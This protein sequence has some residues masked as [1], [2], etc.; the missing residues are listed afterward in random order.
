MADTR[1]AAGW[2]RGPPAKS[3]CVCAAAKR[4]STAMQALVLPALLAQ[5]RQGECSSR[6]QASRPQVTSQGR[7][8]GVRLGP[9]AAAAVPAASRSFR[10]HAQ[11][12]KGPAR[13]VTADVEDNNGPQWEVIQLREDE[14][15]RDA[16]GE[17][18]K[19]SMPAEMRCFD[20]A[21][22]YIKAGDGGNGATAFRREAQVAMGGPAGGNGGALVD[23]GSRGTASVVA[24]VVVS[25]ACVTATARGR[26]AS[27]LLFK[28]HVSASAGNGGSVWV[29]GD[30]SMTS[31]GVFR[32][33]AGPT[34]LTLAAPHLA[35]AGRLHFR[36]SRQKTAPR[37]V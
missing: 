9:K 33:Q 24:A 7:T 35:R 36:S 28:P 10:I 18:G 15:G 11:T 2:R 30:A 25:T 31:L 17:D 12:A 27:P 26:A 16:G 3:E 14:D 19:R 29:V 23:G 32:K 4:V 1:T 22:V 13:G 6:S 34:S 20:R 21:K 37:R 5:A 8:A